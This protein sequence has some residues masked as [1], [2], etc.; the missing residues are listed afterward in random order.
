[1]GD[2]IFRATYVTCVQ[3]RYSSTQVYE[4]DQFF[5]SVICVYTALHIRERS[6]N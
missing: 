2:M 6:M 5:N 1:M 4:G 3:P